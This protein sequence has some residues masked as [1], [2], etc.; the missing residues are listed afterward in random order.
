MLTLFD[1]ELKESTEPDDDTRIT[2]VNLYFSSAE[3]ARFNDLCKAGMVE[4]YGQEARKANAVDFML[5]LLERQFGAKRPEVKQLDLQL[6]TSKVI[7]AL[8]AAK[9]EITK[10]EMLL[11]GKTNSQEKVNGHGG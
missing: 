1:F 9:S 3:K 10:I 4:L 7:E 6:D 11:H 5:D 8:E 2:L